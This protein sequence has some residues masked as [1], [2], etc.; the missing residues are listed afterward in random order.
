MNEV[1]YAG[2]HSATPSERVE[3]TGVVRSA[4]TSGGVEVYDVVMRRSR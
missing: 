3:L 2:A 1:Y 4:I